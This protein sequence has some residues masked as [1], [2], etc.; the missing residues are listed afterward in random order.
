MVVFDTVV[1]ALEFVVAAE[2]VLL[3]ADI[4]ADTA[5]EPVLTAGNCNFLYR[6]RLVDNKP[7]SVFELFLLWF[8][9][10]NKKTF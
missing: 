10:K 5:V 4:V 9:S 7:H 6:H 2:V 8:L 1:A 3:V